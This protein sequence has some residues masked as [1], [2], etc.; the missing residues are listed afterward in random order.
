VLAGEQYRQGCAVGH[1]VLDYVDA[2]PLVAGVD[3]LPLTHDSNHIAFFFFVPHP[4]FCLL[5]VFSV[6]APISAMVM[7]L[8]RAEGQLRF[9]IRILSYN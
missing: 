6:L 1:F 9:F 3:A 2:L 8:G 4:H 5:S 7:S